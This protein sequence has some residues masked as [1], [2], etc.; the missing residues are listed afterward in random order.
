MTS[1]VSGLDT[2]QG[3]VEGDQEKRIIRTLIPE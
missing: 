3:E 1:I 2:L